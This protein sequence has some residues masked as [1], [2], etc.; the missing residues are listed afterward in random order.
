[1]KYIYI[2][3]LYTPQYNY[4]SDQDTLIPIISILIILLANEDVKSV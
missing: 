2:Y 4:N 1:M 3:I